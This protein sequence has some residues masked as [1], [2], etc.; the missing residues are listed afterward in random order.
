[1]KVLRDQPGA[2]AGIVNL[3][4]TAP[5]AG[6]Q[7]TVNL[8]MI[9][10]QLDHRNVLGK[11]ATHVGDANVQSGDTATPGLCFDNHA[12]LPFELR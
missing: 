9:E 4:L 3:R 10:L 1:V 5:E 7:T 11:I 2:Q 12:G 6:L 8:E